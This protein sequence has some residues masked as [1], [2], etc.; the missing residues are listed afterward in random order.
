MVVIEMDPITH[1][2]I[3]LGMATLS[4]QPISLENPIVA[5]MTLGAMAPDLDIVVKYWGNYQYLKHHRGI[6]HSII[7]LIGISLGI[8]F[9]LTLIYKE[10]KFINLFLWVLLGSMSH[11]FFDILNSY[12]VRPFLPF[13]NK[14]LTSGILMLY[15]PFI[16]LLSMGLIFIEADRVMKITLAVTL[17]FLYITFRFLMKVRVKKVLYSRFKVED[18]HG[19]LLVL[20]ALM[21]FFKWDFIIETKRYNIVGQINF[22]NNKVNI[23]KKLIKPNNKL[24]KKAYRTELGRYFCEFTPVTHVEIVEHDF[25]TELKITDL[26][27]FLRNNFMHHVTIVFDQN[28]E[29][30]ESAFH[31]YKYSN[32]IVVESA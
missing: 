4:G 26:R 24:I 32:R 30:I 19:K 28:K 2:I 22:L 17:M 21:N 10:S 3:G 15:D 16:T 9:G 27:F 6:S 29:V 13:S 12:G 11:T 5:G 20:P 1:G 25:K 31:P 18:R 23:R 8:S 14:K 7:G